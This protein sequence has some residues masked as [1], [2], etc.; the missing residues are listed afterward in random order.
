[1]K[2]KDFKCSC[3]KSMD[4]VVRYTAKHWEAALSLKD[5]YEKHKQK[6]KDYE[7][8]I[9]LYEK[10]VTEN[11]GTIK[12]LEEDVDIEF[13]MN[14]GK[15]EELEKIRKEIVNKQQDKQILYNN[16]K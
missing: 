16:I 5:I 14:K 6:L 1:M 10:D 3:C 11:E 8:Q 12:Q 2:S 7:S 9:D 13:N 4:E 15:A